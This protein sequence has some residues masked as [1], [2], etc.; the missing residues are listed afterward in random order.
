MS[1]F[2]TFFFP[3]VNELYIRFPPG[4]LSDS[5]QQLRIFILFNFRGLNIYPPAFVRGCGFGQI[6][7]CKEGA[8]ERNTVEQGNNAATKYILE[9]IEKQRESCDLESRQCFPFTI[10]P[11]GGFSFLSKLISFRQLALLLTAD[12]KKG[13]LCRNLRPLLYISVHIQSE[14]SCT[15]GG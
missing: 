1:T 9:S 13:G 10:G 8:F 11:S 12:K 2:Q 7:S 15:R 6:H 3:T 5:I 4:Q 14:L